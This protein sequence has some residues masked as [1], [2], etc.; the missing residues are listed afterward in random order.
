MKIFQN[1]FVCLQFS[2]LQKASVPV[3]EEKRTINVKFIITGIKVKLKTVEVQMLKRPKS[4]QDTFLR[5]FDT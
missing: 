4:V 2:N 1:P 5:T 3:K